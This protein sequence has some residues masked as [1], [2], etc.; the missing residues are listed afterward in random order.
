MD[1]G[2][3][4]K[5]CRSLTDQ[6][7]EDVFGVLT[8]KR[9]KLLF[10][11]GI[12]TGL[13]ISELLSLQIK[14][15]IQHGEVGN[16]VTVQK[17]NTKGKIESKTLPLTDRI[18]QVLKEYLDT[19]P[20]REHELPLF[21]STKGRTAITRMQ[22]HRI[23]KAAFN[24]LKMTGNLSTHSCRKSFAK[25]VHTAMGEKIEYTQVALCHRS[26]SSTASYVQVNQE[27]VVKAILGMG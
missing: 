27:T 25:R 21:K 15:V 24:E 17:K 14:D 19:V 26:L 11:L 22:A 4:M 1:L 13:R 18:R 8:T 2:E 12:K 9:D 16:W 10:L 5:G 6:E 7:I 3:L 20:N 23:L